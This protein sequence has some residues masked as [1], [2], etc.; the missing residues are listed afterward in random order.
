MYHLGKQTAYEDLIGRENQHVRDFQ[1]WLDGTLFVNHEFTER[2]K[3]DNLQPYQAI[4]STSNEK[5]TLKIETKKTEES[6]SIEGSSSIE[7]W[8]E[9]K[10]QDNEESLQLWLKTN[11]SKPNKKIGDTSDDTHLEEMAVFS[12][13]EK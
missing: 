2:T 8:G 4:Q 12:I 10:R 3:V 5:R 7:T 11:I 1:N 9:R 6:S 13:C